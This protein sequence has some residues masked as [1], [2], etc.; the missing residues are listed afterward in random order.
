MKIFK[1]VLVWAMLSLMLQS[2]VLLYFEK[3]VFVE[4]TKITYRKEDIEEEPKKVT[5]VTMPEEA[6]D[7]E[8]S[9]DGK[10][11]AY[12]SDKGLNVVNTTTG[13][14]SYGIIDNKNI[15][16]LCYDWQ[17]DKNILLI[18]ERRYNDNGTEVINIIAHNPSSNTTREVHEVCNYKEGMLVENIA[19]STKSSVTYVPVSRGGNNAT[20][21]RIDIND[22][23]EKL[24]D[25]VASLG[26]INVFY[27]KDALIYEDR[28]KQQ[29]YRY[30]NDQMSII[31]F[32]N[33]AKTT[34]LGLTNNGVIYAGIKNSEDK[35]TEI[36]YGEDKVSTKEWKKTTLPE[37]KEV[38][39]LYIVKGDNLGSGDILV[40][41]KLEGKVINLTTNE[42]VE[43]E[44][45]FIAMNDSIVCSL[46]DSI[47]KIK[48]LKSTKK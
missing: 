41:N 45:K 14:K 22:D 38:S 4:T 46:K 8:L 16:I 47:L 10:F 20:I 35:I 1:R 31:D 15:S 11:V 37:P 42:V 12:M 6:E 18:A 28:I 29:Y 44:G 17:T 40:N 5:E 27:A 26:C 9:Y 24:D 48:S 19:N 32:E 21:Y 39:D 25:R 36:V 34:I 33:P 23:I 7:F 13:K 3:V 2:M 43:Y 30:S